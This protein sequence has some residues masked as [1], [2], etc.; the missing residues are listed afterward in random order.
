METILGYWDN[1]AS[2]AGPHSLGTLIEWKP[3]AARLAGGDA[4]EVV[5]TRWG[6]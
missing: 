5:P 1:N 6:H 2:C 4:A 3:A